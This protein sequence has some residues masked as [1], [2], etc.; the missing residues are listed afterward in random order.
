MKATI[1]QVI[2][3]LNEKGSRLKSKVNTT[4]DGIVIPDKPNSSVNSTSHK[5]TP[6]IS[7]IL[8]GVAGISLISG[9][10]AD[11]TIL[12]LIGIG[13][14]CASGYGGYKLSSSGTTNS[15][16][17]RMSDV[18]FD[19]IKT[20]TTRKITE[21]IKTI[22]SDWEQF[23]R[24]KH[25]AV[26]DAVKSS[27]SLSDSEKN[28]RLSKL[29]TYEV[30]DISVYDIMSKAKTAKDSLSLRQMLNEFRE[31]ILSAIERTVQKQIKTY[32]SIV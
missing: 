23:M 8:Y 21:C 3:D 13:L 4:F 27:D 32:H 20:E 28:E 25:K 6:P 16:G 22:S 5:S 11:A 2:Q 15:S 18:N 7:Y 12:K 9:L 1:E 30:I 14:G 24:F 26:Q 29:Y 31:Q 17:L 10:M 19:D